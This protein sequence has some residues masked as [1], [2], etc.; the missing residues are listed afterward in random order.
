MI[1][2]RTLKSLYVHSPQWVQ[3]L[4]ATAPFAW[5]AG[6]T[7]RA[8]Q[9][10]IAE[11]EF[12]DP[13]ATEQL[14]HERLRA[15]LSHAQQHVPFY[16]NAMR[17]LGF[18]LRAD[19]LAREFRRLPLVEKP[20]LQQQP[21]AF[22]ARGGVDEPVYADNTG[23][24]TGTPFEFLKN[25]R[26]YPIEQAYMM[27]QWRRVGYRPGDRK[28]TLRGR[29]FSG[30]AASQRWIYNPIYHEL[31]L[32]SYHL[33]AD[34]VAESLKQVRRFRP[35]FLHGYPSA[36]VT[37]LRVVKSTG[38]ELPA[39]IQ[40]VLCGSEPTYDYQRR[41][42]QETL[43]C[44][45]YSWYGQSECVLLAGECEHSSEYHSFPLYGLLELVDEEGSV[46]DRPGVEGEIVG[47][48]LNNYAMPF[49]RYRTGDR[50]VYSGSGPCRCGRSHPR[51]ARVTG[52]KQHF[53]YT[54]KRT[55]VPVTAFVFGQH[56]RAFGRLCALQLQQT[57]PGELVVRVVRGEGYT[58]EDERELLHKMRGCVDGDLSIRFEYADRPW[59][60]AAGKADIVIQSLNEG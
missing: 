26:M 9:R 38:L 4:Y 32:S 42:I 45:V 18:D 7:F 50:G 2:Y 28:V 36:I 47:T 15:L 12:L 55:A 44:R 51:L 13:A 60:N 33:D 56:F 29:T 16:G 6:K 3:R 41:F 30:R 59:V 20:L 39:G 52:R 37:F 22:Q 14:Q 8:T 19:D 24:S 57:E 25:N 21:Q 23:G 53:I 27:A 5:R 17:R 35:K 43:G 11:T 31:V 46:I 54:R 34:T 48:S 58:E 1:S 10:L 49:L 40:A